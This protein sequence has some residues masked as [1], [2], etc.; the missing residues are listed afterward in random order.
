MELESE[1]EQVSG[2]SDRLQQ[3]VWNLLMNAIKFTPAGGLIR[4]QLRR[5]GEVMEITV[6]D[7]GDGISSEFLP[8]VFDRFRQADGS[9]TR[10]YGGMGLGLS[11]VR[12]LVEMHGGTVRVDSPGKGKGATFIVQ[13]PLLTAGNR[14]RGGLRNSLFS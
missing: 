1:R 6:S 5:A 7:S 12:Y 4:V 8:F 9:I 3:V 13:L 11:I 10:A 14:L 2:D